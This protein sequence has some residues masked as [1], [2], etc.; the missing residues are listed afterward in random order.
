MKNSLKVSITLPARAKEIYEAWLDSKEHSAFTGARAV[1]SDKVGGKFSA[2][3]D[4]ISGKNLELKSGKKIV[5][6]WRTTDFDDSDS[7]SNLEITFEEEKD[8]TKITLMQTGIPEGQKE[9]LEKGWEDFYF[10]PMKKYFEEKN[11]K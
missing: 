11:N 10:S 6:S 3:D 1:V 7:D 8:K 2:W 4:Y 9:E 5:Q